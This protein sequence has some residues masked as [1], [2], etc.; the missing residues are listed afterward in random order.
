MKKRLIAILTLLVVL[1]SFIGPALYI[2]MVEAVTDPAEWYMT[3]SGVL[4]SDYYSLYPYEKNSLTIGFSKFGEMIDPVTG[5]GLNYSGRDPFANEGVS[6]D[7]WLNGWFIEIRYTH[8]TYRDRY[9]WAYAM[10]ADM[11]GHGGDWITLA[12]SKTGPPSGG[13]KTNVI[14]WTEPITV[15]Y[16]GPR[17]FVAKLVTHINDTDPDTGKSWSLVD[18]I[19]TIVFNKVK[20][21]VIVFKDIKLTIDSK[22]LDSPVNVQFSNRG[23]WDL[24][25]ADEWKSFAHFYHQKL[26]TCYGA[27][28]H[29]SK[30]ITREY[31]YHVASFT[32]GSVTLPDD[33]SEDPKYSYPV[34]WRSERVYVDG[35]FQEP[36]VDYT[37]NYNN[38]TITFA[39]PLYGVELLVY[40]K[41]Y[42][43]EWDAQRDKYVPI[44]LPH[45]YDLVQMISDDPA[46]SR[47][48]G[49]AAF[50]PI[51]SDYTPDGWSYV[52]QSLINVDDEDMLPFGSEPDIPF[53]IG[54]W[55][56]MLDYATETPDWD[57]QFRGVTVYGIVN[58]HDADD[59]NADK[60][61]PEMGTNNNIDREVMYQLNEIFN[62]W[63]LVT[64]VHKPAARWVEFAEITSVGETFTTDIENVP[65]IVRPDP[66]TTYLTLDRL[67][68]ETYPGPTEWDQYSVFSERIINLDTGVLLTRGVHYDIVQNGDGTASI[69]FYVTGYMKILYSTMGMYWTTTD[70][71]DNA[72]TFGVADNDIDSD[73]YGQDANEPI[74]FYIVT[75]NPTQTWKTATLKIRA[76]DVDLEDGEIDAVYLNGHLLGILEGQ[77]DDWTISEFTFGQDPGNIILNSSG[78][79]FVQI[80][81]SCDPT[82]PL[83]VT[84]DPYDSTTWPNRTA[85][86]YVNVDW[87]SIVFNYDEHTPMPRYE[88]IT[89]GRDAH[90]A[91]SI[92]ASLVSAAFKDKQIEI[93][94]AGFDMI[95]QE[96]GSTSIPYLL[97]RFGGT[98]PGWPPD[99]KDNIYR[100]ALR[101][102]WC[103][104]WPITS[105]NI[106][107]IGGPLANHITEYFNDF[108][109]AFYGLNTTEAP[110]TPYAPW[111]GNVIAL[112]C[113]TKNVYS[114]SATIGYAV[115]TTYKDINGTVGFLIWGISARDTFYASKFFHEEIIFELQNFPP[116]ATSIIIRI[117]YT[118]PEHPTFTVPEVLGTISETSV[119]GIKGGLHDP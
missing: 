4:D 109:D 20:K 5:T 114:A 115:I 29:M 21:Y 33:V 39:E 103:K 44:D 24:G 88:W 38:G 73:V 46:G 69:T 19:F 79:Q 30:K 70:N 57:R 106:I 74:E 8:R 61:S 54:E 119:E 23:E 110:F 66:G 12:T 85:I 31:K 55:D 16:D 89:V 77:G 82:Y 25:P 101:D 14:A 84:I 112:S 75:P 62:P 113:W 53:V 105:S 47:V 32:G 116:C 1:L 65:V 108:T 117:D 2:N 104:T 3:V 93:G 18:V 72:G 102:D 76:Y 96:W 118:D 50:W 52:F 71:A 60:Y 11:G 97:H 59:W 36:G 92:G 6:M 43:V 63:D 40:Y 68:N 17:R 98:A 67:L 22:I 111:A 7:Y 35:V 10:F 64:A 49:F 78:M 42:K 13:R 100:I 94:N 45:Q 37:I 83:P 86:W 80:F 27:G 87:G 48:V 107:G 90:S 34:V 26:R 9:V 91:D 41:L 28:W 56:F 51:L 15:L 99:Y 95:F 58:W 81:V